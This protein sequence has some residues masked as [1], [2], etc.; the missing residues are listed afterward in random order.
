[1][2]NIR[3]NA[4]CRGNARILRAAVCLALLLALT[5]CKAAPGGRLTIEDVRSLADK[6][7]AELT[8]SDFAW[9]PATE[10]GSGLYILV[11]ETDAA[12]RLMIG[13]VPGEAPLYV[14][15]VSAEDDE[16]RIDIRYEDVDAFLR[17]TH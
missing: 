14:Y 1:M 6:K 7:G 17:R 3:K 4:A 5:A 2:W 15:L 11:Y 16:R 12:Y 10:T 8:W 13:G 9:Y